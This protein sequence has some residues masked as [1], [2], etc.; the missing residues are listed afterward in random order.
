MH[1]AMKR[2]DWMPMTVTFSGLLV[3]ETDIAGC[4][5]QLNVQTIK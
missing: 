2:N 5:I 3:R 1:S 4:T